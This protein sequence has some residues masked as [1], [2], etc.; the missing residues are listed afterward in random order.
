MARVTKTY[1]V[2][3]RKGQL[4]PTIDVRATDEGK[5]T[6]LVS[7][8]DNVDFQGD[9]VRRGA[10][11]KSLA[12][13]RKSG[14]PI[15]VVVDHDWSIGGHVGYVDPR[16]VEEVDEGLLARDIQFDLDDPKAARVFKLI[17][18]RRIKEWSFA[19][20][21]IRQKKLDDGSNELLEL[22][23]LEISSTLKGANP[24][25]QTLSAK[26]QRAPSAVISRDEKAREA[27]RLSNVV[28]YR[29][30]NDVP[31]L[32]EEVRRAAEAVVDDE[33]ADIKD[34]REAVT[35]AV[36]RRV[37]LQKYARADA[38]MSARWAN[39]AVKRALAD[40]I[41]EVNV[42]AKRNTRVPNS[43]SEVEV[44]EHLRRHHA[45]DIHDIR[46]RIDNFSLSNMNAMHA[47][48]HRGG[49]DHIDENLRAQV[50]ALVHDVGLDTSKSAKARID[51]VLES[52][53]PR[54]RD[55]W[56]KNGERWTRKYADRPDV[57]AENL[58]MIHSIE[59][60][61]DPYGHPR[62]W[63]DEVEREQE[64][65]V[66]EREQ[67][68]IKWAERKLEADRREAAEAIARDRA[69]MKGVDA[70]VEPVGAIPVERTEYTHLE[71]NV[72][73][74]TTEVEPDTF[75]I[76]VKPEPDELVARLSTDELRE[77]T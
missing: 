40:L 57:V 77:T 4:Y 10:F 33:H 50:E 59:L 71:P 3:E 41:A 75:R 15:P 73:D 38:A 64:R 21:T 26:S 2:E 16:N 23:I 54:T 56:A 12:D 39:Y 47:R 19:Y 1:R 51:K 67:L 52:A 29:T 27:Q 6:A 60:S 62:S 35:H 74:A 30:K 13:W 68:E 46:S 28:A 7:V 31:G 55:A 34:V 61:E 36:E 22:E 5:V 53:G 18:Q 66:R 45:N 24:L 43:D 25:T 9:R 49:G 8:W 44:R 70:Y 69:W 76:A 65:A 48:F 11:A 63:N 37:T 14:D 42:G 20:N 17:K 58:E 32:L 72:T